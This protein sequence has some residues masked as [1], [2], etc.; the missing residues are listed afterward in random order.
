MSLR[1]SKACYRVD[2]EGGLAGSVSIVFITS[3]IV[4]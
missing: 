4:L 3:F 1:R 2:A